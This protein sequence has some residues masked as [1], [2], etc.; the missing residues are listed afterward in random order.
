[1]KL[2]VKIRDLKNKTKPTK[3]L[4][5][6]LGNSEPSRDPFDS[7]SSK[8]LPGILTS[9]CSCHCVVPFQLTL[10]IFLF[11]ENIVETTNWDF[12]IYIIKDITAHTLLSWVTHRMLT[13]ATS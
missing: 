9:W 3:T 12:Q 7:Q 10:V 11:I 4:D 5:S 2:E 8:W 13:A 6:K 1:M